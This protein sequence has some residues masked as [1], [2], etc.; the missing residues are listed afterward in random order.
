MSLAEHF[1]RYSRQR[2]FVQIFCHRIG[3]YNTFTLSS[4]CRAPLHASLS[5]L[6]HDTWNLILLYEIHNLNKVLVVKVLGEES[7]LIPFAFL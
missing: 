3:F 4:S 1:L 7:I 5:Q 6:T 2:F